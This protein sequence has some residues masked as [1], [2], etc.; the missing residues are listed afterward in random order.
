MAGK[1]SGLRSNSPDM[2]RVV[3]TGEYKIHKE[4]LPETVSH[5]LPAIVIGCILIPSRSL[6]RIFILV[7]FIKD[8]KREYSVEDEQVDK[9]S[10]KPDEVY[11]C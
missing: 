10:F 3:V 1:L 4:S 5:I 7:F 8:T 11:R 9:M 6:L 2:A